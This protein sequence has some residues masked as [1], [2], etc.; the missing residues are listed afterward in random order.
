M[1]LRVH[2]SQIKAQGAQPTNSIEVW[3]KVRVSKD[4]S[5]ESR[6]EENELSVSCSI[7]S[8]VLWE[9]YKRAI[10][11]MCERIVNT[12]SPPDEETQSIMPSQK[13]NSFLWV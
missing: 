1:G 8:T 13:H 11:E 9:F 2:S 10:R 7:N 5:A 4:G 12:L 6:E 3:K